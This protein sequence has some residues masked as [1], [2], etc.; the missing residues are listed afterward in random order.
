MKIEVPTTSFLALSRNQLYCEPFDE[1]DPHKP[2]RG[3]KIFNENFRPVRANI[4]LEIKGDA[5]DKY[6]K[7]N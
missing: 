5:V 6:Q 7:K 4:N 2:A 3:K 1:F